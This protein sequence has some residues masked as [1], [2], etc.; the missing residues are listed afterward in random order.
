[1]TYSAASSG[2]KGLYRSNIPLIPLER[3]DISNSFFTAARVRQRVDQ[4][5]CNLFQCTTEYVRKQRFLRGFRAQLYDIIKHEYDYI[6]QHVKRVQRTD[7]ATHR[8]VST[9]GVARKPTAYSVFCQHRQLHYPADQNNGNI[10]SMWRDMSAY[11]KQQY[12]MVAARYH[13]NRTC[14]YRACTPSTFDRDSETTESDLDATSFDNDAASVTATACSV[15][16]AD[17]TQSDRIQGESSAQ[18][19]SFVS[20]VDKSADNRTYRHPTNVEYSFQ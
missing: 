13:E 4:H 11:H 5:V 19:D 6:K 20:D 1:M 18:S 8:R 17:E 7:K 10:Q 2:G 3:Y 16:L 9:K 12:A 15:A 14:A